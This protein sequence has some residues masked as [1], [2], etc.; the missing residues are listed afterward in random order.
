MRQFTGLWQVKDEL[1]SFH[2]LDVQ[3]A[4]TGRNP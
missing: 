4:V 1:S 3:M 2:V